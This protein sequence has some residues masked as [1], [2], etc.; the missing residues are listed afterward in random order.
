ME[1]PGLPLGLAT[2]P[3]GR[4]RKIIQTLIIAF[5]PINILIVRLRHQMALKKW[6]KVQELQNMDLFDEFCRLTS[7]LILFESQQ[8]KRLKMDVA[9]ELANEI[10]IGVL[11]V[12]F[13]TSQTRTTNGLEALFQIDGDLKIGEYS[14]GVNNYH[15]FVGSTIISF[16]SFLNTYVKAQVNYWPSKSKV[17]VAFYGFMNLAVRTMAMYVFFVPSLGLLDILRH[18]Q[19]ERVP[20]SKVYD[21]QIQSNSTLYFGNAPP[22]AWRDITRLDYSNTENPIPPEY[23][24]YTG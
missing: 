7:L 23:S 24:L 2:I 4:K 9:F 14:T 17:L 19:A 13:A 11:M 3:S 12:S 22:V 18:Y 15:I 5:F 16:L 10:F 8:K 6:E 1:A 21:E 20:F